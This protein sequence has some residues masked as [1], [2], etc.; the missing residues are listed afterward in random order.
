MSY[1]HEI[2]YE[3]VINALPLVDFIPSSLN[4][5]CLTSCLA[6]GLSEQFNAKRLFYMAR[7]LFREARSLANNDELAK[8]HYSSAGKFYSQALE[9]T[10]CA[11]LILQ[12]EPG[13]GRRGGREHAS[14]KA[15]GS[16]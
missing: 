15:G 9:L 7:S 16:L 12:T 6:S 2:S 5:H 11:P 3:Q 10:Q 8:E 1:L 14:H 4:L 13:A